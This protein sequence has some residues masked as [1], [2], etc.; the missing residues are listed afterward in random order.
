MGRTSIAKRL[1]DDDIRYLKDIADGKPAQ[2]HTSEIANGYRLNLHDEVSWPTIFCAF[3]GGIF[4]L[5]SW[6][7]MCGDGF[8]LFLSAIGCA[9]SCLPMILYYNLHRDYKTAPEIYPEIN[10][11]LGAGTEFIPSWDMFIF[12]GFFGVLGATPFILNLIS[13]LTSGYVLRL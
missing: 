10:S 6:K 1:R 2:K 4:T 12:P 13:Y 7:T 3:A 9:V 5:W 8:A 11:I